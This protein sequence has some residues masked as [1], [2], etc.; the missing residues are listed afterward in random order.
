MIIIAYLYVMQYEHGFRQTKK[1]RVRQHISNQ[2]CMPSFDHLIYL[3]WCPV[4]CKIRYVGY[5]HG[6]PWARL[7]GHIAEGR[8]KHKSPKKA[9]L[10]MLILKGL[11]PTMRLIASFQSAESAL[12]YEL[13]LI[14]KIGSRRQ[15]VN[16]AGQAID[17][18]RKGWPLQ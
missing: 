8:S 13:E 7:T 18:R 3:L 4:D 16:K 12:A 5:T 10:S 11:L 2:E 17:A 9:W 14:K 15:L 1:S 6:V